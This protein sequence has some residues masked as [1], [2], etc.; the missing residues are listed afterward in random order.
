MA[1]LG[2]GCGRSGAESGSEAGS[3]AGGAGGANGNGGQPGLASTV[4]AGGIDPGDICGKS[5]AEVTRDPI[6]VVVVLD[7]SQS[8]AGK[9]SKTISALIGFVNDEKSAGIRIG[10][11]IF[12][13]AGTLTE[14]DPAVYTSLALPMG[15]LPAYAPTLVSGMNAWTVGGETPTW[16]ALSGTYTFAKAHTVLAPERATVVVFASDG[17]PCCGACAEEDIDDIASLVQDAQVAGIN[18]YVVAID[19]SS[20]S[21]LDKIAAAGGTGEALDITAD[22][23]LFAE[24]LELIRHAALGCEYDI[25]DPPEGERLNADEVNVTYTP[26]GGGEKQTFA[27]AADAEVCDASM[28]WYY[29]DPEEP[30]QIVLCPSTCDYVAQD[31]TATLEVLFGCAT[32]LK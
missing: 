13:A 26:G 24:K 16:G 9:W 17:D 29:D 11:N 31:L 18:T 19:G 7:R 14:C 2:W 23:G 27:R 15:E 20:V 10:V 25:P 6:D 30:S 21:A 8:M 5:V 1:A 3:A 32:V 22:V 12:P 28:A 4:G